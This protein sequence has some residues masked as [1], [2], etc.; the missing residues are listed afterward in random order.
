MQKLVRTIIQSVLFENKSPSLEEI[1][2][3]PVQIPDTVLPTFVT[4]YDDK[5]V[6]GSAGR[7]Y[8]V[9]ASFLEELIDNT[10]EAVKD[11][12]CAEYRTNPE[13]ARNLRYRV[14]TF[15][16][17]SRRML[18]HPDDVDVKTEGMILICRKQKKVGVILPHM[19]PET[20][21]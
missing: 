1:K 16:N 13:K 6:I 11:P 15:D 19:L 5:T 4:L 9:K 21:S 14:D 7:L 18:H 3:I 20:L 8:P 12:R 17:N 10:E 2:K